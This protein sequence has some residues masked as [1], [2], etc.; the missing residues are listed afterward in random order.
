M[1]ASLALILFFLITAVHFW[2]FNQ[3]FYD[4]EHAKLTL[5]GKSISEHI[6]ITDDQLKDLTAFTL[7]YLNDKDA[8]LDLQM[9]VKGEMREV[10]TDDEKAHM[11]DVRNLNLIANRL[12]VISLLIIVGYAVFYLIKKYP[13]SDL[14]SSYKKVLKYGLLFLA[15]LGSW[16]LI[17]FDS[18]WTAFHHV[19]FAGNDL[20]I[21]DLRKD[22][23]IMIVP[24]EFFNHLVITI[25]VTF[26]VLLLSP[27]VL[28][29]LLIKRKSA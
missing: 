13:L 26:F 10:Y 21:L 12:W 24:P 5:Y 25:T 1:V 6:G 15:V 11:I 29:R 19:F 16:I 14:Y 7:A 28:Y 20:W 27:I 23:L 2:S 9:K 22:I 18:F 4:S 17:D 8:S 3:A